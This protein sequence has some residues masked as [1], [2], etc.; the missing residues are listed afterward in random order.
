LAVKL[1]V[2]GQKCYHCEDIRW[3]NA[4]KLYFPVQH[5]IICLRQT[6][7]FKQWDLQAL[8]HRNDEALYLCWDTFLV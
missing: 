4:D 2:E 1:K 5:R 7:K 3:F 6:A 8:N